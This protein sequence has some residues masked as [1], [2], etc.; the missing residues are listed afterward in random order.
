MNVQ[1]EDFENKLCFVNLPC[2]NKN[3]KRYM[4]M[5]LDRIRTKQILFVPMLARQFTLEESETYD[6]LTESQ[7]SELQGS[8]E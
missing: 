1:K 2:Y 5:S 3:A 6:Y 7:F 8:P 4:A